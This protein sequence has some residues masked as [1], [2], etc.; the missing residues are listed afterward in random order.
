MDCQPRQREAV[1]SCPVLTGTSRQ[2]ALCQETKS[3]VDSSFPLPQLPQ[4]VILPSADVALHSKALG[5][6]LPYHSASRPLQVCPFSSSVADPPVCTPA[7]TRLR[8]EEASERAECCPLSGRC[9]FLSAYGQLGEGIRSFVASFA[10]LYTSTIRPSPAFVSPETARGVWCLVELLLSWLFSL[11]GQGI[12]LPDVCGKRRRCPFT[13]AAH[14]SLLSVAATPN[15]RTQGKDAILLIA[16]GAY[17][18]RSR[19]IDAGGDVLLVALSRNQC[20]FSSKLHSTIVDEDG[21]EYSTSAYESMV[22]LGHADTPLLLRNSGKAR[23]LDAVLG[24]SAHSHHS[25]NSKAADVDLQESA[26]G[27]AGCEDVYQG[28]SVPKQI[29]EKSRQLTAVVVLSSAPQGPFLLLG[30]SDGRLEYLSNCQLEGGCRTCSEPYSSSLWRS[31]QGEDNGMRDWRLQWVDKLDSCVKVL[32]VS[33]RATRV[34][35]LTATSVYVFDPLFSPF[36]VPSSCK[37]PRLL[38]VGG[39]ALLGHVPVACC[40]TGEFQLIVLSSA[41][42]LTVLQRDSRKR[43][44]EWYSLC[45][46]RL[47]VPTREQLRQEMRKNNNTAESAKGAKGA[48]SL[49]RAAAAVATLE[50]HAARQLVYVSVRGSSCPLVFDWSTR[51]QLCHVSRGNVAECFFTLTGERV[52]VETPLT[53]MNLPSRGPVQMNSR[54]QPAKLQTTQRHTRDEAGSQGDRRLR[55]IERSA[56]APDREDMLQ[57]KAQ[58][59]I[60]PKLRSILTFTLGK[61]DASRRSYVA[62]IHEGCDAVAVYDDSTPR[63]RRRHPGDLRQ[64]RAPLLYWL[65]PPF[66]GCYPSAVAFCSLPKYFQTGYTLDASTILAV[67]WSTTCSSVTCSGANTMMPVVTCLH[68]LPQTQ[69]FLQSSGSRAL[70]RQGPSRGSC[71]FPLSSSPVIP[72]PR[73][74]SGEKETLTSWQEASLLGASLYGAHVRPRDHSTHRKPRIDIYSGAAML[75]PMSFVG[76]L[77]DGHAHKGEDA[78]QTREFGG[79]GSPFLGSNIDKQGSQSA[80]YWKL[81]DPSQLSK[82]ES[83][84]RMSAVNGWGG[85]QGKA[86]SWS[87]G[88]AEPDAQERTRREAC[89]SGSDWLARWQ[90]KQTQLA[91]SWQLSPP[92]LQDSEIPPATNS[93]FSRW[94]FSQRVPVQRA[95]P[96]GVYGSCNRPT[97]VRA[98]F[99]DL[100]GIFLQSENADGANILESPLCGSASTYLT[101]KSDQGFGVGD[102]SDF[103]GDRANSNA[104]RFQNTLL[105]TSGW[106]QESG[107]ARRQS[108]LNV[109][110]HPASSALGQSRAA[111]PFTST[112]RQMSSMHSSTGFRGWGQP[113][114]A[115]LTSPQLSASVMPT[116]NDREYSDYAA[117]S[118]GMRRRPGTAVFGFETGG[119][120]RW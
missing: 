63:I 61:D 22:L 38:A 59:M 25:G 39:E 97:P 109:E 57:I 32:Q 80:S 89:P 90:Q 21:D 116:S 69:S 104:G 88:R 43:V 82:L 103:F 75:P 72:S 86:Q 45:R 118:N 91:R 34:C 66:P 23:S 13:E 51:S 106:N 65:R 28:S 117:T 60:R 85:W 33:P 119:F 7:Y 114:E 74:A 42:R 79:T 4:W 96:Y 40:W 81:Q 1:T 47:D 105:G 101:Y 15:F 111:S 24:T 2:V 26:A 99:P 50:F 110:P 19:A 17:S 37:V 20:L 49:V 29:P 67:Q 31:I 55:G 52:L 18:D 14:C 93:S 8:L 12:R 76:N 68:K 46:A 112:N 62:V 35:A 73:L 9:A 64:H 94:A 70:A 120:G 71:L 113:Q 16:D 98:T 48:A 53:E 92:M 83:S 78:S 27:R 6:P 3:R 58:N 5:V 11:F 95:S 100:G 102:Y 54:L 115:T 84:L 41:G 44:A 56:H 77:T 10:S 108:I 36:R 107:T 87:T 30:Y